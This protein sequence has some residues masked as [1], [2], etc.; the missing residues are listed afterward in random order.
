[1]DQTQT[2]M[3]DR[4]N[5]AAQEGDHLLVASLIDT[6]ADIYCFDELSKTALH[7]AAESGNSRIVQ[8]LLVAGASTNAHD[9]ERI[10]DT[11]I[12]FAAREGHFRIVKMLLNAGADPYI[13]GWMQCDALDHAEM[14]KDD[15]GDK[16]KNLIL[17]KCPPSK[18]RKYRVR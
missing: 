11:P 8:M 16:M 12:I 3:N 10:G 13:A 4:L 1:M 9:A 15:D 2:E 18:N 5:I 14:R 6:G 17:E 7:Y